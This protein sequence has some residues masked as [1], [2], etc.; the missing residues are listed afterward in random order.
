MWEIWVKKCEVPRFHES[1]LLEYK[2]ECEDWCVSTCV[3]L[4]MQIGWLTW[5]TVYIYM[6]FLQCELP[7][8]PLGLQMEWMTWHI[9]YID[10]AFLQC[11][12]TCAPL[13]LQIWWNTWDTVYRV[14]ITLCTFKSPDWVN[15]LTHVYIDMAS[16]WCEFTCTTL[17]L[18]IGWK[19]W[20]TVYIYEAERGRQCC[21]LNIY[22]NTFFSGYYTYCWK[23]CANWCVFVGFW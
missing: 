16:L 17:G 12:F 11:E 18:Q 1:K 22:S 9:V 10:M 23:R 7:C 4:G 3:S 13:G 8:M 6:A 20:D 21:I 15:D 5:H 14:W 19:T 2:L